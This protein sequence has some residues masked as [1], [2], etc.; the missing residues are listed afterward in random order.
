MPT[1][2][3]YLVVRYAFTERPEHGATVAEGLTREAASNL[4]ASLRASDPHN[5]YGVRTMPLERQAEL[6][7]GSA[8]LREAMNALRQAA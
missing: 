3:A 5:A 6:L 7:A 4:A 1:A 8:A 2:P